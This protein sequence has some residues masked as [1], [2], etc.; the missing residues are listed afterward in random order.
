MVLRICQLNCAKSSGALEESVSSVGDILLLQEPPSLLKINS[1]GYR[2]IRS[3]RNSRAMV[4]MSS[5]L[6]RDAVPIVVEPD[7]VVIR[8]GTIFL[9]SLYIDNLIGMGPLKCIVGKALEFPGILGCD[10]NSYHHAWGSTNG[11]NSKFQRGRAFFDL[12]CENGF[13]VLNSGSCTFRSRSYDSESCIDVS[14]THFSLSCENWK[15][16]DSVFSD[17]Q[18]ITF[19]VKTKQCD[20][21][22]VKKLDQQKFLKELESNVN[23]TLSLSEDP[24]AAA[25]EVY[26]LL[27]S[28]SKRASYSA[29]P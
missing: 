27:V 14:A 21:T 6:A 10:S 11:P 9:T 25:K 29:P 13:S 8:L 22:F 24:E 17:H 15:V 26:E 1:A 12:L 4:G 5:R 7:L 2:F 23:K 19:Q 20:G 16:S 28:A 18:M 3:G